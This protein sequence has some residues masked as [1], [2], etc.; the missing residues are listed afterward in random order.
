MS[1][2]S[3]GEKKEGRF[4]AHFNKANLH[5]SLHIRDFKSSDSAL[6]FCAASEC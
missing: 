5:V 1:I 2:L 4:T 6:Y 3:N